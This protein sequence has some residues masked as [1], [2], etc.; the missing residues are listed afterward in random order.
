MKFIFFILPSILLFSCGSEHGNKVV[1]DQFTVYFTDS[2]D[3]EVAEKLAIYFRENE[4][5][6]SQK[7][8]VQLVRLKK[9]LQLRMIAT[10]PNEVKN[11]SFEER[12]LLTDL[13]TS[14]YN[15]VIKA[16]FELVICN[17]EFEPIYNL[18]E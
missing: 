14:L 7:Q 9:K 16:P 17:D 15:E 11:M 18:N 5:I 12:K 13:Q 6:A 8:D 4:L 3:Q 2:K 10:L 1:G